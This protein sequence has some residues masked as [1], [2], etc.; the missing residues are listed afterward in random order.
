MPMDDKR[1]GVCVC[2]C[3]WGV[4]WG[5]G[6]MDWVWRRGSRWPFAQ[7]INLKVFRLSSYAFEILLLQI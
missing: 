3:V 2:V 4:G 7:Y 1:A 5:G 6:G